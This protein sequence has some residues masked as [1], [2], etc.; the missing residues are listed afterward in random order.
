MTGKRPERARVAG[1]S[2]G[3]G[4][5]GLDTIDEEGHED[6]GQ[7]EGGEDEGEAEDAADDQGE[8][9]EEEADRDM[10]EPQRLVN[11]YMNEYY[12]GDSSGGG[13][14]LDALFPRWQAPFEAMRMMRETSARGAASS[15]R[16]GSTT[17]SSST[18]HCEDEL[19]SRVAKE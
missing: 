18:K 17:R 8:D 15:T 11:D 5:E 10:T 3:G 1:E 4:D 6:D 19:C 2:E 7:E 12:G 14:D 13:F 9:A 16:S